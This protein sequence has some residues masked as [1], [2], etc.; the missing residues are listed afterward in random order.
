ML[1]GVYGAIRLWH[2]PTLQTMIVALFAVFSVF[3]VTTT[4]FF[5]WYVTWLV[6]LAAICLPGAPS[7]FDH[8]FLA[9]GLTFSCTTLATYYST[10]AGW[11]QNAHNAVVPNWPLQVVLIAFGVP[12][13]VGLV[14]A[15]Y[16]PFKHA[17]QDKIV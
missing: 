9:F 7:R 17:K 8:G 6:A 16:W 11:M 2:K 3:L 12:M 10:I 15:L 4:W 13:L 5:S 14:S 1:V